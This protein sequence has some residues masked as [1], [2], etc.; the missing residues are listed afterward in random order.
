VKAIEQFSDPVKLDYPH[1]RSEPFADDPTAFVTWVSFN[2]GEKVGVPGVYQLADNPRTLIE[3]V[4]TVRRL[5]WRIALEQSKKQEGLSYCWSAPLY[6]RPN[7]HIPFP[8]QPIPELTFLDG[9]AL[10]LDP[11]LTA[12]LA[13]LLP[14]KLPGTMKQLRIARINGLYICGAPYRRTRSRCCRLYVALTKNQKDCSPQCRD[15]R[16]HT[17]KRAEGK[18]S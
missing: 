6:A 8:L 11:D 16:H 5:L 2:P 17:E 7:S 3:Q 15:L 14:A 18:W 9:V 10:A 1:A 4:W 13:T 12:K